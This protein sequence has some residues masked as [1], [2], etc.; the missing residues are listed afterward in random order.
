MKT[1]DDVILSHITFDGRIGLFIDNGYYD[2]WITSERSID[3]GRWHHLAM[4]WGADG[5]NLYIDGEVEAQDSEF[6]PIVEGL[7]PELRFGAGSGETKF[8][9]YS[10]YI[11]EIG[12]WDR[13]LTP[14]EIQHQF[15]AALGSGA[16]QIAK[17]AE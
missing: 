17:L 8:S 3:D 7:L 1:A 2:V 15:K 6:R 10:G 13:G 5:V 4:S 9:A 14:A 16:Q 12:L 11:D